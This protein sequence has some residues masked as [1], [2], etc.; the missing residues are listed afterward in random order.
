MMVVLLVVCGLRALVRAVPGSLPLEAL[1]MVVLVALH[2]TLLGAL[3]FLLAEMVEL[4]KELVAV[5]AP[6]GLLLQAVGLLVVVGLALGGFSLLAAWS[7][8]EQAQRVWPL[9]LAATSQ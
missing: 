2:V 6:P 5:E 7:L 3:T 4:I 8:G 9:V 1:L